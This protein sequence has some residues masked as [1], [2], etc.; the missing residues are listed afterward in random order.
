MAYSNFLNKHAF[1]QGKRLIVVKNNNNHI[2][3][4][5]LSNYLSDDIFIVLFRDP[6]NQA[7]SL[8]N[9]HKRLC[10]LQDEDKYILEYM[11]LIGHREFGLNQSPFKYDDK[12]LEDLD[13][14]SNV[15]NMEINYW[16]QTWINAYQW[17]YSNFKNQ[18][19]V[20]FL[21]YEDLCLE[22]SNSFRKLFELLEID[23]N[24][25]N[26]LMNKNSKSINFFNNHELLKKSKEIY[27][28]LSLISLK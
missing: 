16:L 13:N 4:K 25:K 11:N 24:E 12:S 21:S 9:T 1:H 22:N 28:N 5:E 20:I 27:N 3:L 8:F 19:N 7:L 14:V 15:G 17:L 10:I 2:R 26:T 6:L 23:F 18:S